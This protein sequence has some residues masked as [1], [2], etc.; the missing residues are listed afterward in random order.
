M[1][2]SDYKHRGLQ[3]N[4]RNNF[5]E[6]QSNTC[7]RQMVAGPIAHCNTLPGYLN[8]VAIVDHANIIVNDANMTIIDDNGLVQTV[9]GT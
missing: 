6:L 4:S 3:D 2:R 5:L 1:R 9:A 8:S 7:A